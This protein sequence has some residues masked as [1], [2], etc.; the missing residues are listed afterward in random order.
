MY[1]ESSS[2]GS[3][4]GTGLEE[5]VSLGA[6]LIVLAIVI[7]AIVAWILAM[8]IITRAARDKGYDDITGRLWFFG[9]I[10]TFFVPAII[11]AALPNKNQDTYR[12]SYS[13]ARNTPARRT[14]PHIEAPYGQA[15]NHIER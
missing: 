6:S 5:G 10:G 3:S 9:I 7:C 15:Q 4:F 8:R 14:S 2:Y 12:S 1:S 13:H 11:V